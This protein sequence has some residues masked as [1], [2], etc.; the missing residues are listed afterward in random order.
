LSG[1]G[2]SQDRLL[3]VGRGA[4]QSSPAW[5]R[6]SSTSG[7]IRERLGT[8]FLCPSGPARRW[9]QRGV[10]PLTVA[11]QTDSVIAIVEDAVVVALC[12]CFRLLWSASVQSPKASAA[13]CHVPRFREQQQWARWNQTETRAPAGT[14][15]TTRER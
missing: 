13:L 4:V 8:I 15:S 10:N 7:R 9:Q 12:R 2:S 11:P 6:R 3:S 14:Y 1:A 5:P